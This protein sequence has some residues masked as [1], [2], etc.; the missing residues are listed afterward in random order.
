MPS[1]RR[2]KVAGSKQTSDG[3]ASIV[4]T[5]V[6][7]LGSGLVAVRLRLADGTVHRVV[8]PQALATVDDV[9][10]IGQSLRI[11]TAIAAGR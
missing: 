9:K 8:I 11:V 1:H 4:V 3:A 5:D 2:V 10:W 7:R 6:D